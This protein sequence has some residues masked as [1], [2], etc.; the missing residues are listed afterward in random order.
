M[1]STRQEKTSVEHQGAEDVAAL[2]GRLRTANRRLN[3]FLQSE[4]A[5]SKA[6]DSLTNL[7]NGV[8]EDLRFGPVSMGRIAALRGITPAAATGLVE[9]LAEKGLVERVVN[10]KNRRMVLVTLTPAG[11]ELWQEM[12]DRTVA[13]MQRLFAHLKGEDVEHLERWL[14]VVERV[15][16]EAG[17][18]GW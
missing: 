18:S 7:Q 12:Y 15:L 6:L 10:Q 4:F 11:R 2:I 14:G 1:N 17:V 13:H 5:G 8:L 16:N 3:Q 9:R